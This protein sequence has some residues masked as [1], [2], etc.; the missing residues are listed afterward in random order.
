M[1]S[2][3]LLRIIRV[4][5]GEDTRVFLA[6]FVANTL[7]RWQ[8]TTMATYVDPEEGIEEMV[9]DGLKKPK[10]TLPLYGNKETMNINP[11]ILSN[12]QGSAYFKEELYKLKTFHEVVDEIYY[13]VSLSLKLYCVFHASVPRRSRWNTWSRGRKGAG[14]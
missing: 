11:M 14:S 5:V 7:G 2:L 10:N 9:V 1:L 4:L 8:F 12:I 13:K 3:E 6:F